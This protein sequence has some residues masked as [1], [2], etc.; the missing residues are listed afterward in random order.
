MSKQTLKSWQYA[1]LNLLID[2]YEM[3]KT[4][5]DELLSLVERAYDDG[6]D[7]GQAWG[8]EEALE[9]GRRK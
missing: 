7:E 3:T 8:Y 1:D 6:F 9:R 5:S 4:D 2:K